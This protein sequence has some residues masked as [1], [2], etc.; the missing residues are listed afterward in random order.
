MSV[1]FESAG[2]RK[3][4]FDINEM[5][6]FYAMDVDGQHVQACELGDMVAVWVYDRNRTKFVKKGYSALPD[7]AGIAELAALVEK[8]L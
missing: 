1:D 2:W 6:Q 7:D 3:Y 5:V 8:P 4:H